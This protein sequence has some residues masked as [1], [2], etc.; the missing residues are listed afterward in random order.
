M[1]LAEPPHGAYPCADASTYHGSD[2]AAD[3]GA[4]DRGGGGGA[5]EDGCGGLG[6]IGVGDGAFVSDAGALEMVQV[7]DLGVEAVDAAVGQ[8]DL[9]GLQADG[10]GT[11]DTAAA[12]AL[13]DA[14]ADDG[15]CGQECVALVQHVLW[16]DGGEECACWRDGGGDGVVE[17]GDDAG[18]DGELVGAGRN[19]GDDAAVDIVGVEAGAG[20]VSD[21]VVVVGVLLESWLVGNVGV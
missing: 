13:G 4:G 9:V 10:G 11:A 20:A 16:E 1:V 18:S 2:S 19:V 14:A 6:V 3:H 5:A 12:V 17:L 8:D 15:A 21:V 7:D